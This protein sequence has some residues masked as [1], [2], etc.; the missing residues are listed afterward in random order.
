MS[1]NTEQLIQQIM[2]EVKD[3]ALRDSLLRKIAGSDSDGSAKSDKS[4]ILDELGKIGLPLDQEAVKEVVQ[5]EAK[6]VVASGY[7]VGWVFVL[8]GGGICFGGLI[9]D[10]FHPALMVPAIF[11]VMGLYAIDNTNKR[12]RALGELLPDNDRHQV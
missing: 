5:Q 4:L 1:N 3:P 12:R 2:N 10:G 11:L 7:L 9:E 6:A 8:L